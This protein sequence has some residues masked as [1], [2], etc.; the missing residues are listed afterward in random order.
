M[1]QIVNSLSD[2]QKRGAEW[3]KRLEGLVPEQVETKHVLV[4]GCGS[5]GSFMASE[6]IRS[7]VRRITLVDPDT[8]EW[9]NLTRTVY[10]HVDL[11]RLKVEAL[12]DHILSIFP[13]IDVRCFPKSIQEEGQFAWR[14]SDAFVSILKDADLVISAVDQPKAT[15]LMNRYSYALGKPV[16]FVGLYKG[17]KGG[18]VIVSVPEVTPCFHCSTG[19]VRKVA[20]DAGL[21][22]VAHQNRDYGTNRL[23]AEVALGSDIHFVC[24]VAV[25]LVLSLLA[26]GTTSGSL[27]DFMGKQLDEGCNFL[28]LGMEPDYFLFPSTHSAAVGQYAFQS[29]WAKTSNNPTCDVCGL[30][31]NRENSL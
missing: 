22:A 26:R 31:E 13:D 9:A 27:G 15:G 16:V 4:V 18:E 28:M 19:G 25:K 23:I 24:S 6:L 21:E 1:D 20:E 8:V 5:V 17:A 11:G 29:I 12:R 7:G 3:R 2:Q 14:L 30:P 10:K